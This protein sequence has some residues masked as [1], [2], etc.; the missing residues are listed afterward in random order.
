MTK[1]ST[2]FME[3]A[4]ACVHAKDGDAASAISASNN[5]IFVVEAC[6]GNLG[7]R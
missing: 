7:A 5:I 4:M 3:A 6:R 1:S 2:H